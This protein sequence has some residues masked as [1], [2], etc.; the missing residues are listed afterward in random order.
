MAL[1]AQILWTRSCRLRVLTIFANRFVILVRRHARVERSGWK[2]EC[3]SPGAGRLF[4]LSHGSPLSGLLGSDALNR[5]ILIIEDN[6]A[7]IRLM[8]EALR[9]LEP[10]VTVHVTSDSDDALRFLRAEGKHSSAPRP[11]LVFLDFNLPKGGSLD[12][13]RTMKADPGLRLLPVAILTSSDSVKDIT[14]AYEYHA[15]CYLT[16]VHDLDGFF[17][18]IRWAAYFWLDIATPP[19]AAVEPIDPLAFTVGL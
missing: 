19:P 3:D 10:A 5:D 2:L 9:T 14:D 12:L 1:S 18:I 11:R 8:Q 7:D 17:Q 4:F 15:N 13:L 16:K 6:P